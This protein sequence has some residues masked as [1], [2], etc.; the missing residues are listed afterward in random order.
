MSD[1]WAKKAPCT[2]M[3]LIE[4]SIKKS[5]FYINYNNCESNF[6]SAT[7]DRLIKLCA[8]TYKE[9]KTGLKVFPKSVIS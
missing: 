4:V 1:F 7:S 3:G 8:H 5:I 9:S 6:Y 2:G